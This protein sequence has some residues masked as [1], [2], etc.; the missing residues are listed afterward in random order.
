M[1]FII[2]FIDLIHSLLN[3][4]QNCLLKI[5]V[6]EYFIVLF[7]VLVLIVFYNEPQTVAVAKAV[8]IE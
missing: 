5:Y 2:S 7:L 6:C 3:L 8:G 1:Y 4:S